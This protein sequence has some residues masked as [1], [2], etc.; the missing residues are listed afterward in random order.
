MPPP[1]RAT[2]TSSEVAKRAGVSRTTVS[3]V[4]ND[5][6]SMGIS[7]ETRQ[8][9]LQAA[10]ELGYEPNAAARILAGG[11]TGTIAVV[12]PRS[13]HLHVDAYLPRLLCT[14]NDRCHR[15]GYKVLLESADAWN[16][17]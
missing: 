14:I 3:F 9:V 5:V 10:N 6:R 8:K 4:L 16:R 7:E 13:D 2:P 1:R 11:S 17:R 12:I 15:Q